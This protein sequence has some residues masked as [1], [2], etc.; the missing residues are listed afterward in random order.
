[1]PDFAGLVRGLLKTVADP[2]TDSF[3]D[4]VS[5]AHCTGDDGQGGNTF[6]ATVNVK[7]LVNRKKRSAYTQSGELAEIIAT[8]TFVS[9]LTA[10][11]GRD[12][13][14]LADGTTAPIVEAGG[15]T[16]PT[17]H[18]AFVTK[19]MLGVTVRGQ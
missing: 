18:Q 5:W 10:V 3:Q 11:D 17:T 2:M 9:P 16:D 13:F 8:L 15:F 7:A 4:T 1:M 6:A 19:V 14:T 12:I